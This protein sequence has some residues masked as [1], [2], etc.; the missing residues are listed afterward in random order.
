MTI[1]VETS[2]T[3]GIGAIAGP[4]SLRRPL[5]SVEGVVKVYPT[6]AG[7]SVLA[8]DRVNLQ[9]DA[10][11]FVCLVGPSGC[12]KTTLMRLLAG[13]D[14]ADAGSSSLGGKVLD[15]PSPEVGVVFQHSN[16]LPWFSVW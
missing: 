2:A 3:A 10:G 5:I 13:L 11:G 9:I 15:G 16:L 4:V 14:H 6:V 1:A 7:D 12:G 8:L